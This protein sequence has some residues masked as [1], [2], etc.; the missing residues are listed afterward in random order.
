MLFGPRISVT[1]PVVVDLVK[2]EYRGLL[3]RWWKK[4]ISCK[5]EPKGALALRACLGWGHE[6]MLMFETVYVDPNDTSFTA[7]CPILTVGIAVAHFSHGEQLQPPL[8]LD[9]FKA[10]SRSCKK[11]VETWL[12]DEASGS[13]THLIL[14]KLET[15][16][17]CQWQQAPG[18]EFTGPGFATNPVSPYV[19]WPEIADDQPEASDMN[20]EDMTDGS[21]SQHTDQSFYNGT[22]NSL[23]IECV[24]PDGT[25]G[26]TVIG[27]PSNSRTV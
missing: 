4:A 12:G 11:K 13:L 15:V 9:S 27:F 21:A 2:D 24:L 22:T 7:R 1:E 17:F 8:S 14:S 25:I 19:Q 26:T 6:P 5:L 20:S 10:H 18:S 16:E 23:S 3:E